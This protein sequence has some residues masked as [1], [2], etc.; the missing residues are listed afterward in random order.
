VTE[1]LKERLAS[2]GSVNQTESSSWRLEI[3]A[4]PGG[5]YR[6]AQLDDFHD[7]PRRALLW[8]PPL[9]L[10]LKAR[11][12]SEDIPGTWGFGLWNDPFGFAF[13]KGG[14][15]RLPVAPNAAWFFFASPPNY[16]SLRDDLPAQGG[17]AATFRSRRWP[18]G[19]SLVGAAALPLLFLPPLARWLRRLGRKTVT[20]DAA[21]LQIDPTAWHG[22][23]IEWRA[24][25]AIFR[26]DGEAVLETEIAPPGPLGLVL[27]VDN[28]YAA[29]PPDGRLRYGTLPNPEAAW[30]ELEELEIR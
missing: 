28:Q 23:T 21:S 16:L 27:W 5:R 24:E 14:G 17:L 10:S 18:D 26:V 25:A 3:P 13:L 6:L 15:V 30:V 4:G 1:R 8:R 2:G 19:L 11:A 29:L 12:S 9:R 20:Q 22:Y 7:L